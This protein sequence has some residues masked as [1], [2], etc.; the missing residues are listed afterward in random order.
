MKR[1]ANKY[2][3]RLRGSAVLVAASVIAA[4]GLPLAAQPAI[5]CSP[6]ILTGA[7]SLILHFALP[8]LGNLIIEAPDGTPY[9]MVYERT[10]GDALRMKGMT[11]LVEQSTFLKMTELK[12]NVATVMGAPYASGR[13]VNDRVFRILGTY[14]IRLADD[15][16]MG[17]T[18]SPR[19]PL[20]PSCKVTLRSK[21]LPTDAFSEDEEEFC[22][23]A[24]SKTDCHQT[25][26]ANLSSR[27]LVLTRS[28]QIGMLIQNSNDGFYGS[29][30]Y[31]VK[32][33]LQ[34]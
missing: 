24:R 23:A 7:G 22:K 34:Q 5:S 21:G 9:F 4:M 33:F 32:L 27:E 20:L 19:P 8:H 17:G 12:L 6:T 14:V 31:G 29:G 10:M 1:I 30:G 13:K 3:P 26:R 16:Y 28:G 18:D 25:F 11:P 2:C 15:D